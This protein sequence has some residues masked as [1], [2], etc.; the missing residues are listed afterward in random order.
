MPWRISSLSRH[1]N[2]VLISF[3]LALFLRTYHIHP[4]IA[5]ADSDLARAAAACADR[6]RLWMALNC[7][8]RQQT[9]RIRGGTEQMLDSIEAPRIEFER[10][11]VLSSPA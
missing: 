7:W 2:A 10:Y 8:L 1:A 4:C 9:C 5:L 11:P 3:A 6:R